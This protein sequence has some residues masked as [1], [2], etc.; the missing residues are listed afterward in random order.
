AATWLA[1]QPVSNLWGAGPKTTA[2]LEQLRRRTI[3]DRAA[4][5]A[6]Q[7]PVARGA[8]APRSAA[9]GGGARRARPQVPESRAGPGSARRLG[10]TRESR[11]QLRANARER[12]F[13]ARGDR[14]VSVPRGESR[15]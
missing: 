1:P 6:L 12:R 13:D 9:A 5:R 2:R 4:L 14:G 7:P 15:C 11:A 10:S 8:R 3:C